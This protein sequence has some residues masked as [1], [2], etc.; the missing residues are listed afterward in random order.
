MTLGASQLM[1][2]VVQYGDHTNDRIGVDI[3]QR[4]RGNRCESVESCLNRAMTNRLMI[5]SFH[6]RN[7]NLKQM[8]FMQEF[9]HID[10]TQI[11]W[12]CK[13]WICWSVCE[14]SI[15]SVSTEFRVGAYWIDRLKS[16]F[17]YNMQWYFTAI[18]NLFS[19][20][21]FAAQNEWSIGTNSRSRINQLLGTYF[22]RR[23]NGMIALAETDLYPSFV[24]LSIF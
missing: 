12:L 9:C 10:R 7:S 5:A 22:I 15:A 4:L 2:D 13:A 19:G 18:V 23:T 6:T 14:A 21:S 11:L 16:M 24:V 3:L 1:L 20:I 8:F 17:E